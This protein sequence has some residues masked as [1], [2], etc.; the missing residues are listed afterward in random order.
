[1]RTMIV[2]DSG[3]SDS[4]D[5]PQGATEL[6]SRSVGSLGLRAPLGAI[7]SIYNQNKPRRDI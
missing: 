2:A 5:D 6:F 7:L 1:M 3:I 4:Q